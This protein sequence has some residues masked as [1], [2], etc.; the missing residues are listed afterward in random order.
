MTV[1]R[2]GRAWRRQRAA[3][4][5]RVAPLPICAECRELVD[6]SLPGTHPRGPSVDHL[7]PLAAGGPELVEHGAVLRLTHA[8]CN[9]AKENRRR[10]Q[11]R[12]QQRGCSRAGTTTGGGR[13]HW[14]SEDQP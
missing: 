13:R 3:F 10:A 4:L 12:R 8:A 2:G 5:A 7:V 6:L 14:V 11:R 1:R 9:S